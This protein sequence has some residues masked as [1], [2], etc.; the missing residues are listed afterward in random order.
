MCSQEG[1]SGRK[2]LSNSTPAPVAVCSQSCPARQCHETF[3]HSLPTSTVS[4][5]QLTQHQP[6]ALLNAVIISS[7]ANREVLQTLPCLLVRKLFIAT[8]IHLNQLKRL[9]ADYLFGIKYPL[10][11]Q[12]NKE[13]TSKGLPCSARSCRQLPPGGSHCRSHL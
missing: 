3:C 10:R 2:Q 12:V 5:R 8:T 7:Y 9:L 4:H 1:R 11:S 6:A 13:S